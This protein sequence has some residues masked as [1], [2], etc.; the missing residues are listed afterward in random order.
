MF[1]VSPGVNIQEIDLTTVIP[2]VS[3]AIGALA[4]VFHWGPVDQRIMVDSE[5]DLVSRFG[6]PSNFNAETWFTAASYLAYSN[7]LIISRAANT[8][9]SSPSV[10]A[11]IE[12]GNATATVA[13]TSA[14]SVGMFA[15]SV[16]NSGVTVGATIASIVNSTAF[17]F[18]SASH[19]VANGTSEILFLSN[20]AFNAIAN[21]GAVANLEAQIVKNEDHFISKE[22]TFDTDAQFVARFPGSL[23]NSLRISVCASPDAFSQSVNLAS[24][25]NASFT[26]NVNSNT[27]TFSLTSTSNTDAGANATSLKA[28][29]AVGD[30]IEVGNN[31]IGKQLMK[32]TAIGNTVVAGNSST[33]NANFTVSFEDPLYLSTSF[34]YDGANAS[35]RNVTRTWEFSTLVDA[36]PGQSTYQRLA[37]NTSVNADEVHV[38]V[39]DDG[40]KFTGVPGT[41]LEIYKNLSRASDAKTED[42]TTGFYHAVINDRSQYVWAVNDISG[43]ASNTA[44]NLSSTTASVYNKTFVL[45]N[46]G[47]NESNIPHALL[48]RAYDMFASAEDVDI[49][50]IMTGRAPDSLLP[51]YL[52]DNIAEKRKDCVVFVSPSRGSVVSNIG[53]EADSI[54]TFRNNLRSTSYAFMDSGYKY[55]YDRYNNINRF[56]PLNGDMAGLCAR[57]DDT[58]DA[59]WS[60]GG[61]NRGQLKNVIKLAYNPRQADRDKL[62]KAGVNPVVSFPGQG[63]IL[64]GDKTLLAKPSAFDR[65]NV[66]RLFIVLEKSI[67]T[68]AKYVLFDFNDDFTRSQFKNMVIPYLRTVKGRR[69]IT[70]F[71][72]VCDESNNTP[73]IVDLNQFLGAI[74]IKPA[75]SINFI[76][77]QFVAVP[78]GI[79]FS[80]V[81]GQV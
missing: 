65:I 57:T 42:G 24:Y 4:G 81:V 26:V 60:P 47:A 6:K 35:T 48:A 76:T 8:T 31:E 51:N 63:T 80:E 20:T 77:L 3:T 64:Y 50:L 69:G 71:L 46:D 10:S 27:T 14:L 37:G 29:F 21:T 38:V 2:T 79:A 15:A 66:R 43:M 19:A 18:S 30:N 22:G 34:V 58:N 23:G 17:T 72:V 33:G 52:I 54:V 75:R 39:V 59:W 32:I 73:Q 11:S 67:S 49:S 44:L 41:V 62:Y 9:G 78:T 12:S 68:A 36:A 74:Y 56:I 70:D 61:F 5:P 16:N 55:M 28:L 40:G 7:Q 1:S 25:S 53:N 45:G 13:N